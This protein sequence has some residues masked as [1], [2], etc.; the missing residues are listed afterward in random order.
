MKNMYGAIHNPNRY[1][2]DNCD[3]FVADVGAH[4]FVRD[5]LRLVIADALV[6]QYDGGPARV[7][8][9]QWRPGTVIA[10]RDP[11]AVD[12]VAQRII[13]EQ[14]AA[15]GLPTLAEAKR[16]PRWLESAFARGLGENRIGEIELDLG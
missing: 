7:Q 12:R 5:K 4:P 1:H 6:A 16:P 13:E 15:H 14:R 9:Y 10:S 2:D 3:P 8:T 11:V